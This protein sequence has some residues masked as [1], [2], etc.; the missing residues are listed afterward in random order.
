[1]IRYRKQRKKGVGNAALVLPAFDVVEPSDVTPLIDEAPGYVARFGMG[2]SLH[3][4]PKRGILTVGSGNFLLLETLPV[5]TC[6]LRA[7]K[8]GRMPTLSLTFDATVAI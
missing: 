7:S 8:Y 3:A 5:F 2:I 1:M 4:A 6:W